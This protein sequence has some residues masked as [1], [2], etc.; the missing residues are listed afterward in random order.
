MPPAPR[1]RRISYVIAPPTY[2]VPRLV[3]PKLGADRHGST[4]PLLIPATH[5]G[6]KESLVGSLNASNSGNSSS[7]NDKNGSTVAP[8]VVVVEHP[9]HRLGISS[10]AL[11][12]TTRLSGNITPEGILY[13]GG[14][15]GQVIAHELGA[16]LKQRTKPYGV[17][18]DGKGINRS[19]EAITGWADSTRDDGDNVDG[20]SGLEEERD[21]IPFEN[22]FELDSTAG[23]TTLKLSFRQ[24]IQ[25]HADWINDILL[26]NFNRTLV[27]CSSDGT[28]KA[29]SPHDPTLAMDPTVIGRHGDY[30]RCLTH[31]RHQ[32]W[33]ASGAFD[34]KVKIWD[35]SAR[36]HNPIMVLAPPDA[37]NSKNS[38]YALAT[39]AAG[40]FIAAGSPERVIRLWDARSGKRT[41]KLVGH[42]DNIRSILVSDDGRYILTGSADASIK[43]WS[44]A[45]ANRCIHTFAHHT[46][47]VWSLFSSHPSL[48]VFYSGDRAGNVCRVDMVGCATLSE[49]ECALLCKEER[50]NNSIGNEGINKI[51]VLDDQFVWTAT[52]SSTI[53]CYKVPGARSTRI[54]ELAPSP[55]D[56]DHETLPVAPVPFM[57]AATSLGFTMDTMHPSALWSRHRDSFSADREGWIRSES[58]SSISSPF[59]ASNRS[60]AKSTSLEHAASQDPSE[61]SIFART[62]Q[63][64]PGIAHNPATSS[65]FG[66]AYR[67][68]IKLSSPVD[69]ASAPFNRNRDPDV[70]TLYSAAS[71]KSVPVPIRSFTMRTLQQKEQVPR[72]S[73]PPQ[74]QQLRSV[75]RRSM[76]S[77]E[78]I[79]FGAAISG[80]QHS[81][82]HNVTLPLDEAED[83][84]RLEYENRDL[85]A[86]AQ[87]VRQSPDYVIQGTQGIVRSVVLNDRWHALTVD[88]V[89]YVGVW[90]IARGICVGGY[91]KGDV[92]G[93]MKSGNTTNESGG[94][95]LRWSPKEALDV[96]QE[97][98]EGEAL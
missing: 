24:A 55:D 74:P 68:L 80:N 50:S 45:S 20:Q 78:G 92:E 35:L 16:P 39:D 7:N 17:N 1:A 59:G 47:S 64:P 85:A 70:S 28:V 9:Q 11:D 29:W 79:S 84:A 91:E 98:I 14:R 38:V 87:P 97:R 96:V 93:A 71:I 94:N 34:R 56:T 30:V 69:F 42:T 32:N 77:I 46:E 4:I 62:I 75:M 57:G 54:A 8:S 21:A 89:G 15:D 66:I 49:G 22:A 26:C 83:A 86:D 53:N 27:S 88:T 36:P 5:E 2:T 72:P 43:L 95:Q 33:V 60:I 65:A 40:S 76:A 6:D 10:L 13:S 58:P 3:L 12:T 63:T 67:S 19:W 31:P 90:D 52:A 61:S 25:T 44:M 48:S 51:Q 23:E 81:P 73:N 18:A 41:G 82:K 37:A